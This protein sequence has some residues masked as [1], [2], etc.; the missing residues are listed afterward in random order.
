MRIAKM[1]I[2]AGNQKVAEITLMWA[3]QF[4]NSDVQI[5]SSLPGTLSVSGGTWQVGIV[6]PDLYLYD[7]DGEEVAYCSDV[8]GDWVGYPLTGHQGRE[9]NFTV[10]KPGGLLYRVTVT[11]NIPYNAKW[12]LVSV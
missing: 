7:E 2:I 11:N 9:G 4:P 1:H 10:R 5:W 12:K 8:N 6:L 3:W